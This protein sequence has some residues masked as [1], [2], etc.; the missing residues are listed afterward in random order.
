[1]SDVSKNVD[2]LGLRIAQVRTK[3]GLSQNNLSDLIGMSRPNYTA[4]EN[5]ISGRFL[6]D[7]QLKAIAMKLNVSSDYLLGLISDS[8]P[9]ADMMSIV[10]ALGI[11]SNAIKSIK[12]LKSS[13][14]SHTLYIFDNFVTSFDTEFWELL[15]LY[16]RTKSFLSNQYSFVLEFAKDISPHRINILT[17]TTIDFSSFEP[18]CKYFYYNLEDAKKFFDV[19]KKIVNNPNYTMD[20]ILHKLLYLLENEGYTEDYIHL[21]Q[22]KSKLEEFKHALENVKKILHDLIF[23]LDFDETGLI[24][25]ISNKEE[26]CKYIDELITLIDN[27]ST[28][29]ID[30]LLENLDACLVYF[31]KTINSSLN[32]IKYKINDAFN[33]YLEKI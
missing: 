2:G 29:S 4:I 18:N 16:K 14:S 21:Y 23:L 3:L 10:N 13:Y 8:T 32:F 5:E 1:M 22:D 7:Y 25:A 28:Q 26:I 31:D 30:S 27:S 15:S 12:S 6:K 9:N 19:G 11:S 20:E 24:F 17:H 33:N